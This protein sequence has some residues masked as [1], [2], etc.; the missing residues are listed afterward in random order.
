[1]NTQ[2]P[3]ESDSAQAQSAGPSPQ[4]EFFSYAA[5][6][7]LAMVL[8]ASIGVIDGLFIG[9]VV[10]PTA[11]AAVNLTVPVISVF[12]AVAIMIS[13]GGSIRA[14]HTLA[15]GNRAE[16]ARTFRT[17]VILV[18]VTVGVLVAGMNVAFRP[19]LTAMGAGGTLRGPTATYLGTMRWFYPVMM[20]NITFGAFARSEGKPHLQLV[21]GMVG[22]GLNVALDYLL[23]VVL[24]WGL[25][26][27][28]VASGVS[29]TVQ[30]ALY[31]LRMARGD[32]VFWPS[33]GGVRGL[34]AVRAVGDEVGD[35]GAVGDEVGA[36]PLP[37]R[38]LRQWGREAGRIMFNGSS[39][40]VGQ[41]GI[42]VVTWLFNR[43]LLTT[44]GVHGVAAYTVVGYVVFLF[45]M[46]VTGF[47]IGLSPLAARAWASGNRRRAMAYFWTA[48]RAAVV[49]GATVWLVMAFAGPTIAALFTDRAAAV[50]DVARSRFPLFAAAFLLLGWNLI[51][52]G[53][54]TALERPV[55]SLAIATLRTIGL[56]PPAIAVLPRIFGAAGIWMSFPAVEAVT[57]LCTLALWLPTRRFAGEPASDPEAE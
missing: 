23:I 9:R 43:A 4:R 35:V 6:A 33:V 32:S 8:T 31:V 28:A 44:V 36:A 39:E 13:A 21:F 47:T 27:A 38:T 37:R 18:V 10:G 34:G 53:F 50:M 22:N 3:Q 52:A 29:V 26:G 41:M 15:M 2:R 5:P 16:A 48:Q 11:L 49:V 1:M 46:V 45:S 12:L 14:V 30:A 7:T 54:F 57:A 42:S 20:L 24:G 40:M 17:T 55:P 56:T 51:T 25:F 19:V